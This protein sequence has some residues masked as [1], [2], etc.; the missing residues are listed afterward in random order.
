MF[1]RDLRGTWEK[2][3]IPAFLSQDG[4]MKSQG[5]S[6]PPYPFQVL[7]KYPIDIMAFFKSGCADSIR[8][9]RGKVQNLLLPI[10]SEQH[11]HLPDL[12]AKYSASLTSVT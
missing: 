5:N 4:R 12:I 1:G 8:L 11:L 6:T 7:Q 9:S 3:Y 10:N 2:K